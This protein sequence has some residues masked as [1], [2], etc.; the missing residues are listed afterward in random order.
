M[1]IDEIK[2]GN[3]RYFSEDFVIGLLASMLSVERGKIILAPQA[4]EVELM[5]SVAQ[6]RYVVK[7]YFDKYGVV[8]ESPL[9]FLERLDKLIIEISDES[10]NF[11]ELN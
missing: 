11:P 8:V 9:L 1:I 7:R 6:I 5:L 3:H 10:N 2:V 4:S